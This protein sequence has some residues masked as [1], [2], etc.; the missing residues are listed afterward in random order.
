MIGG[1]INGGTLGT[2][3]QI[4][5]SP[6]PG[7][8]MQNL[9]TADAIAGRGLAGDRYANGKGTFS[10]WPNDHELTIVESEEADAASIAPELSRRNL[11]TKGVR[12]NELVGRRFMVGAVLCEGTRLCEPCAHLERV[13]ERRDLIKAMTH[14]AGLRAVIVSGG[15]ICVG[16]AVCVAPETNL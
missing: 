9:Q 12:L 8:P 5:V 13:T 7:E 3:V 15:T 10:T 1:A 14:K 16:D 2:I 6:A 11:V 4:F